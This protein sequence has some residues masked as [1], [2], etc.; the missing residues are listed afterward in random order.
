MAEDASIQARAV[1]RVLILCPTRELAIQVYKTA[2]DLLRYLPQFRTVVLYGGPPMRLDVD[3]LAQGCQVLIATP[4]RLL[5]HASRKRPRLSLALVRF[6][7]LDGAKCLLHPKFDAQLSKLNK[8]IG[9]GGVDTYRWL[10]TSGFDKDEA[11]KA[12]SMVN[13]GPTEVEIESNGLAQGCLRIEVPLT[14]DACVHPKPDIIDVTGKDRIKWLRDWLLHPDAEA[15]RIMILAN[16]ADHAEAINQEIY[17]LGIKCVLFSSKHYEQRQR[18]TALNRFKYGETGIAIT[19]QRLGQGLEI[20]FVGVVVFM[21]MPRNENIFYS[22]ISSAAMGG[23]T[24]ILYDQKLDQDLGASLR[25]MMD[26]QKQECPLWFKEAITPT[27]DNDAVE[28]TE[29]DSESD[30]TV[31]NTANTSS[32]T[33]IIDTSRP[34]P[35]MTTPSPDQIA[36]Y[37]LVDLYEDTRKKGYDTDDT[38]EFLTA[39]I[40]KRATRI[41]N[42]ILSWRIYLVM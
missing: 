42:G 18:E 2:I 20:P 5:A 37:K 25:N 31:Q 14:P 30:N 10:F 19:T 34:Q 4:G 41:I 7:I 22:C 16:N 33:D 12:K 8:L 3:H 21:R 29:R 15:Q 32:A 23:V 39:L 38:N 36:Y 26:K 28:K 9:G 13:E 27:A 6:H 35:V 40:Q 11:L 17:S 24:K 1:P